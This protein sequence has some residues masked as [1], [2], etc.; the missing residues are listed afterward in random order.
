LYSKINAYLTSSIWWTIWWMTVTITWWLWSW[1]LI[2]QRRT[3]LFQYSFMY[4]QIQTNNNIHNSIRNSEN[5]SLIIKCF[6]WISTGVISIDITNSKYTSNNCWIIGIK[7]LCDSTSSIIPTIT[8]DMTPIET[9]INIWCWRTT[10][11]TTNC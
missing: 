8:T 6:A 10:S 2:Y 9:P 5:K 11:S 3:Q 1:S 4:N 7:W